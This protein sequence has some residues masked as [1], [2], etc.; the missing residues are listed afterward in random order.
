MPCFCFVLTS[1]V[2]SYSFVCVRVRGVYEIVYF[3]QLI[4]QL[5]MRQNYVFMLAFSHCFTAICAALIFARV[6][7]PARGHSYGSK[8]GT[9]QKWTV[10]AIF[11]SGES[12][13]HTV[14]IQRDRQSR[15]KWLNSERLEAIAVLCIISKKRQTVPSSRN[16]GLS[17]CCIKLIKNN[18]HRKSQYFECGC[19]T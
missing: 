8:L 7:R 6:W 17:T 18:N 15:W 1:I 16:L 11:N 9:I 12:F 3:A 4:L 13:D 5:H 2:T 10:W 19:A 14:Q